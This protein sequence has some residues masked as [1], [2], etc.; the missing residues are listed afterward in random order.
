MHSKDHQWDAGLKGN[1]E[2][3]FETS[4]LNRHRPGA[5]AQRQT[6]ITVRNRRLKQTARDYHESHPPLS[7]TLGRYKIKAKQQIKWKQK[8]PAKFRPK[9]NPSRDPDAID[10]L[11]SV[12][13]ASQRSN[14]MNLLHMLDHIPLAEP[15]F[16]ANTITSGIGAL[17]WR[18]MLLLEMNFQKLFGLEGVGSSFIATFEGTRMSSG[19]ISIHILG[20]NVD[21]M[22]VPDMLTKVVPAF[23]PIVSTI[24]VHV[25]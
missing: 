17:E 22:I 9:E 12:V 16:G 13:Q 21:V 23:E 18:W 4:V 10:S 15:P 1:Q 8:H 6:E 14:I 24:S 7:P 20:I 2:S 11:L 25:D 3:I 5:N 19:I